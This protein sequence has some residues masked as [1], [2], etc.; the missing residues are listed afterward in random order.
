MLA[1]TP[2]RYHLADAAMQ[3]AEDAYDAALIR[4]FGPDGVRARLDARG[5]A[6]AV[7]KEFEAWRAA[8]DELSAAE[9]DRAGFDEVQRRR[10][11]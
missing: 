8:R 2:S 9:D 7:R 10:A 11:A 1:I 6:P 4:E 5:Y 3:A